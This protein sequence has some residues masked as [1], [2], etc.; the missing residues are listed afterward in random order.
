M[1]NHIRSYLRNRYFLLIFI[2][3]F[4][5][6]IGWLINHWHLFPITFNGIASSIGIIVLDFILWGHIIQSIHHLHKRKRFFIYVLF[7]L[8]FMIF[9]CGMVYAILHPFR[10]WPPMLQTWYMGFIVIVYSA[11]LLPVCIYVLSDIIHCITV[12]KRIFQQ[13]RKGFF[14]DFF[15]IISTPFWVRLLARCSFSVVF[16]VLMI[17]AIVWPHRV[18]MK[19]LNF[20]VRNLPVSFDGFRI[21]QI[22]DL[23]LGSWPSKESLEKIVSKINDLNPDLIVF[24]GDL[25]TFTTQEA[26]PFR[27]TLKKL[28][29]KEGVLT[30]LGNHDYGGYIRWPASKEKDKNLEDLY[31][32]IGWKLLLNES[33]IIDK[34]GEQIAI[35]GVENWGVQKRFP[36][37]ADLKKTLAQVEKIPVKILLSHD[38]TYW[39]KIV[40]QRDTSILLTL[41]GHTHG[42]QLGIETRNFRW[43]PAKFIY[44]YWSGL[45]KDNDTHQFLYVNQGLGC[46]GYPGRMGIWP[47]ITL[48]ELK[49]K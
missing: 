24:T 5:L 23:H 31:Q 14:D 46:I 12:I 43:S 11:K 27:E 42:M 17:G 7:W 35:L 47:E 40:I 28:Q 10:L 41:S 6:I 39:E 20:P 22:S 2:V 36:K 8:P 16:I 18:E 37:R 19:Q 30:I 9:F 32:E 26:Y 13:N 34:D 1:R 25:V 45:Y 3:T 29:S 49:T 4:T 15:Y 48:I 44:K 38:P 33:L 21:V